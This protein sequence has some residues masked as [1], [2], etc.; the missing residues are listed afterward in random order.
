MQKY[1]MTKEGESFLR[2]ELKNL[3]NVER[4]KISKAI[5]DARKHVI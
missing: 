5:A 2:K 1:P 4:N 3:K